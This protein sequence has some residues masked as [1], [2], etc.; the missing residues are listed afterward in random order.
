MLLVLGAPAFDS[1]PAERQLNHTLG[2][3]GK[4][5]ETCVSATNA[6]AR[7]GPRRRRGRAHPGIVGAMWLLERTFAVARS[8][9]A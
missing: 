9:L 3:F 6:G 2:R 4:V 1:L 7:L 8:W 5:C